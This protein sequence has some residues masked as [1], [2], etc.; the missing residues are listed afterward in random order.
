MISNADKTEFVAF[1]YTGPSLSLAHN[2][3]SINNTNSIKIFGIHFDSKLSWSN[4]VD[5]TIKKCNSLVYMLRLLSIS[6]TRPQ[7]KRIVDS[8][9]YITLFYGSQVWAS[10][11]IAKDLSRLNTLLLK[12]IRLHCR[13][14]SCILSNAELCLSSGL[15]SFNSMRIIRDTTFLHAFCTNTTNT[16]LTLR[17]IEQ[18][19][20]SS[21]Y[22]KR[23]SFFDNSIHRSGRQSFVHRAKRV[24]E[25]I[26]F[27]WAGLSRHSFTRLI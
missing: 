4:H 22:P 3:I 10:C 2:K 17:L 7:H 11:V 15:R 1:G 14:F 6:L 24:A 13:N 27:E 25:L 16:P 21:R 19:L 20:S 5:K 26:P 12:T 8:H 18:S 23:L 9:F